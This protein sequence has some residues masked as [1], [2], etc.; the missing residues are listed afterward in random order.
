MIG[1]GVV[2]AEVGTAG[3]LGSLSVPS[4]WAMS[5]PQTGA[6]AGWSSTARPNTTAQ[7]AADGPH[8]H[9]FGQGLIAMMNG[10]GATTCA[11]ENNTAE[12]GGN[13]AKCGDKA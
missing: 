7:V 9:T 5:A 2:S 3:S 1:A 11:T 13:D 10:C 12:K 8:G 6:M 4:S